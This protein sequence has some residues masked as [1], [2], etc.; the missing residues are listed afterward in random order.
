M[1]ADRSVSSLRPREIASAG[2]AV[3]GLEQALV[4]RS[5]RTGL[6][7]STIYR[8]IPEGQFPRNYPLGGNR[9]AWRESDIDR[10]VEEKI[11]AGS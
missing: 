4:A 8:L 10:W 2:D 7:R 9:V 6:G 11:T 3:D 5:Q 1:Y